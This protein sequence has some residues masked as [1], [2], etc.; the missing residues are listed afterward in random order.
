MK[1]NKLNVIGIFAVLSIL[2]LYLFS[3]QKND[4]V[5][6]KMMED[7]EYLWENL[8]ENFPLFEAAENK[9]KIDRNQIYFEYK[10]KLTSLK[11]QDLMEF[12]QLL[13]Q[14]L[15]EFREVGHLCVVDLDKFKMYQDM[16]ENNIGTGPEFQ[17]YKEKKAR[18]AYEN[19]EQMWKGKL[20][21]TATNITSQPEN[22]IYIRYYGE[23][24]IISIE[25][26]ACSD[27]NEVINMIQKMKS[28]LENCNQA[29]DIIIDLR[30][31]RG[32]NSLVWNYGFL[33]FLGKDELI[34]TSYHA[35]ING[36]IN[37]E[38]FPIDFLKETKYRIEESGRNINYEI[39]SHT[40]NKNIDISTF[41]KN[42]M[43]ELNIAELERCDL[44]LEITK[45]MEIKNSGEW[46]LNGQIWCLMDKNTASTAMDFA[47][48]LKSAGA[49][50]VG[51]ENVGKM[52]GSLIAPAQVAMMLP[53]TGLI[54]QYCPY[55]VLN[56]DG[57]CAEFGIYPDLIVDNIEFW[58]WE[59]FGK[60]K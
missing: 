40:I 54:V 25:S 57:S 35:C 15:N 26:F 18:K 11:V 27:K 59:K 47:M 51:S 52:G 50:L 16:V 43:G 14:C 20:L 28:I 45:R 4:N 12:Y 55:Y 60:G 31:N 2:C 8:E 44:F 36:E 23:V 29:S 9:Y 42:I 3:T 6:E 53:N 56:E 24:P 19:L 33:P 30:G 41:T 1:K 34:M 37:R 21:N 32:G 13:C 22:S 39:E 48:T 58:L 38:V 7:Y 46:S 17:V 49:I 10:E 5:A